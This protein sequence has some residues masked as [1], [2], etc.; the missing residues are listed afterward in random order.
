MSAQAKDVGGKP[1]T[2][3]LMIDDR[4]IERRKKFIDFQPD[5]LKRVLT[6]R[7]IIASHAD[8]FTKRFFDHLA[9]FPEAR[10]LFSSA[11]L[12]EAKRLKKEH[13]IAMT[14]GEYGTHYVEQR[15]RLGRLYSRAGL[16]SNVFLGAFHILMQSIGEKIMAEFKGSPQEA[17]RGFL[18]LK[19]IAFFDLGIIVDS[20]IFEREKTIRQQQEAIRELSTPVLQLRDRLLILPIV[21][22]ID[23]YRAK[24]LTENLLRAIRSNRAKVV[25]IDITGVAAV[26]SKVANHLVQTVAASRLMGA[27][28]IVTGLSADV[29]MALVALGVELSKLN[30]VGDLQGGLEEAER[31]LAAQQ[32]NRD[33]YSPWGPRFAPKPN[34]RDVGNSFGE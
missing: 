12:E 8:E 26:D 17:F 3:E 18:A 15:L 6:V 7:D 9:L 28:V 19:K 27:H 16:E 2:K 14:A 30:T 31:I 25:V 11:I 5:D 10:G 34:G 32:P 22:M 23:T 13:L 20:I 21:G 4:E 1:S 24:L 29:A 33:T